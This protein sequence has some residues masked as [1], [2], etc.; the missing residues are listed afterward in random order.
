MVKFIPSFD[1]Q[2]SY[3]TVNLKNIPLGRTALPVPVWV[4]CI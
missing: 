4:I 1:L 3:N 2:F